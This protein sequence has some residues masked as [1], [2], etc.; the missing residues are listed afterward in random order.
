MVLSVKKRTAKHQRRRKNISKKTHVSTA[1]ILV[2]Q[3][4]FLKK[5]LS[6]CKRLRNELNK[7]Q[8]LLSE[9]EDS[10]RVAFQQW[11]N[12]TFGAKLSKVRELTETLNQYYFILY[13]L[14]HCSLF[15]RDKL[16]EVHK[17]LFERKK[18]GTLFQFVLPI[19]KDSFDAEEEDEM[20]DE[21]DEWDDDDEWEE[22]DEWDMGD[23]FEEFFGGKGGGSDSEKSFHFN[24]GDLHSRKSINASDHLRI[25]KCYRSLA[26]RLHPDHST[27]DESLR[28]KRWHE[29]QDA[30][31]NN[32]LEALLRVEAICDMDGTELSVNLGLARLTDLARYHQSH[33]QPLRRELSEAKRDIAF[34]FNKSGPKETITIQMKSELNYQAHDLESDI[35]EMQQ[36]ADSILAEFLKEQRRYKQS[37][38]KS[39]SKQKSKKRQFAEDA[40]QMDLF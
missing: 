4:P 9:Y 24:P 14:E 22:D 28:E 10:D 23:T 2:D 8:K 33:L 31:Q 16:P 34:G 7:K 27:L 11:L 13:Q 39:A 32:D 19:D 20:E 38:D 5:A 12:H 18:D 36:V 21:E 25:K 29:I 30:Y 35:E 6:R 17:E 37:A 40:R 1:L 26:K 15:C 3:E